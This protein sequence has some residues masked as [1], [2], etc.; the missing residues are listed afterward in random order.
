MLMKY[1]QE[2]NKIIC[3]IHVSQK[4]LFKFDNKT[5]IAK[6]LY[7]SGLYKNY[8]YIYID[9]NKIVGSILLRKRISSF[10]IKRFWWIYGVFIIEEERGKGHSRRLMKEAL[11]LLK[12]QNVSEVF[13]YVDKKNVPAKNLYINL[14]FKEIKC[15]K[16]HK[17]KT[18]QYLMRFDLYNYII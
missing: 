2:Y 16:Y 4:L 8:F 18:N 12:N 9:S 3:N 15:S 10:S 14:G 1:S 7:Y 13:L 17:L 5:F 11:L 6:I